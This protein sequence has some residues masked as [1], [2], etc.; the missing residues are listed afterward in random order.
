MD[1]PAFFFGTG[2]ALIIAVLAWG[3]N[4]KKPGESVI[5][6]ENNFRTKLK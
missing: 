5:L 6:I 4:L 3:E 1:L 2:I